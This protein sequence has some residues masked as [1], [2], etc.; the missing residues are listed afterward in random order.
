MK[1]TFDKA[2]RDEL[3]NRIRLLNESSVAQW[4]KMNAYQMVKHCIIWEEMI[5]GRRKFKRIFLGYF[6][7]K[8]SLYKDHQI[9]NNNPIKKNMP[10]LPELI[11]AETHGDIETE[12]LKWIALIERNAVSPNP[13]FIHPF[14][15]RLTIEQIG[16]LQYKHTDH[17]LRQFNC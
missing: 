16:W 3:I 13:H 2:T 9:N 12:K 6:F 1:T 11:V 14:M 15:G 17:H 5:A 7:G 4:G 8:R 10:T